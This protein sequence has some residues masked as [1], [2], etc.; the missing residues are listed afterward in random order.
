MN[1]HHIIHQ[2]PTSSR[3][4]RPQQHTRQTTGLLP[5]FPAAVAAAAGGGGAAAVTLQWAVIAILMH[6][7][8][9]FSSSNKHEDRHSVSQA[10]PS[11]AL[12]LLL[13]LWLQKPCLMAVTVAKMNSITKTHSPHPPCINPLLSLLHPT[14]ALS[15][16]HVAWDGLYTVP[17]LLR[18]G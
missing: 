16:C 13:L 8:A 14:P 7:C 6:G 9:S 18:H 17:Q 4:R 11:H 1:G 2:H 5:N 10:L 15:I 3:C 12:L